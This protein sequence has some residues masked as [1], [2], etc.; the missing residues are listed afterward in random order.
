MRVQAW[1]AHRIPALPMNAFP[2]PQ[3]RDEVVS[4]H[5]AVSAF[6]RRLIETTL[7]Q[8]RGNRTHAA[9]TLGLQRTYLLRLIRELQV[10]APPPPSRNGRR[11]A[12]ATTPEAGHGSAP[13]APCLSRTPTAPPAQSADAR[14]AP[15]PPLT[16]PARYPPSRPPA[17]AAARRSRR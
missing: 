7:E 10:A 17:R 1:H 3:A 2:D 13:P 5:G 12:P 8:A 9:R 6:K 11:P 16:A 14:S 4:Y 15:T